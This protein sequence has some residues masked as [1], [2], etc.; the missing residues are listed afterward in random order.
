MSTTTVDNRESRVAAIRAEVARHVRSRQSDLPPLPDC[1]P[2]ATATTTNTT[3]PA[4][5]VYSP[6]ASEQ[7][8]EAWRAERAENELPAIEDTVDFLSRPVEQ[9]KI[10]IDGVLHQ[11][12]KMILGSGS[13]SFKTWTLLDLA[14][15][16]AC[17]APWL[18]IN[19]TAGKVLFLNFE[20]KP[21]SIGSRMN[22]IKTARCL[23]W[24]KDR[25]DLWN[26]RGHAAEFTTVIP[27]IL[28]RV[29]TKGY[30]LIILDPVYK[31]Y[32]DTDE[33]SAG[34]VAKLMNEL[35]RLAVKTNAA[36]VFSAH[37]SK[38]NQA[39]KESVDR[40]SGSGVFARDPDAILSFTKHQQDNAF[41]VES[42]LR[43]FKQLEPFVVKWGY[44]LLARD[45]ALNPDKLKSPLTKKSSYTVDAL[46]TWVA[47][48]TTT[49]KTLRERVIEETG[50][51][52]S[53][54]YELL[55]ELKTQP[56]VT[57][58]EQSKKWIY[59]PPPKTVEE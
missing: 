57:Y 35:E 46:L 49:T 2:G 21:A 43:D 48:E 22:A 19:T 4:S 36:I 34:D 55:A 23:Q 13:K 24:E 39:G 30:D 26:L 52:R 17:G 45:E 1:V 59:T 37:F 8:I 5:L 9:P 31:L 44:P 40:V 54:F 20:L 29:K 7:L 38:G 50:M 12:S 14:M 56:G 6:P 51:S 18:G 58:G 33:N 42:T 27:K 41:V 11:G 10:L 15:S 3:E 47:Q 16:V 53:L 25:F 32:G 28:E